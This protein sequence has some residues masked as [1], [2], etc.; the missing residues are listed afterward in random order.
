MNWIHV[1]PTALAAFLASAVE[2]VEAATI[3]LAVGTVRGWRS[4]LGGT[5]IALVTLAVLVAALGPA[6]TQLPEHALQLFVGTLLLLFG[7][8]WL[9]K[10]VLR[11]AGLI[12]LHDEDAVFRNEAANLRLAQA[13]ARY[14]VD[15]IALATA[16][17]AV[18]LEG[19][20]IVFIVLAVSVGGADL[21]RTAI[22]GTLAAAVLVTL[23][24]VA[25]HRPLTRVPENTLK[26]AVGVVISAFGIFWT[27][28]GLGVA[29]P[30][31]DFS[32]L[33]IAAGL[34]LCALLGLRIASPRALA[35]E[36]RR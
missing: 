33:L 30:G 12:A 21:Q 25:V 23:A 22:L 13:T 34:L 24:A 36:V 19:V 4:A 1:A 28:E 32:L 10:A 6:L 16:F 31:G 18:L 8:R 26:F 27:G 29:W 20:E 14:G 17:K 9:R 3:V 2:C 7:M 5:A 35:V 11:S 15:P